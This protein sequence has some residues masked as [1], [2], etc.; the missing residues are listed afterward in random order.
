MSTPTKN[1]DFGISR[2]PFLKAAGAAATGAILSTAGCTSTAF[3]ANAFPPE[4]HTEYG[5]SAALGDGEVSTFVT[6]NENG[7]PRHVG[8]QFSAD[9][10]EGLP[11]DEGAHL[12][13]HLPEDN[14]THY[15]WVG[16]DWNPAGHPPPGVYTVEH[17]D[18]H[19]YTM[20]EADVEAIP[21]GLA[22]YD[23]PDEQRPDGFITEEEAGAP[24]R[25]IA[26]A[27][28]EHLLD[29][30]APEFDGGE[31]SHTFIYG[32]YDP[33]IDPESPDDI[34]EDVPIGP[35]GAEIDVPLYGVGSAGE[36]TFAEPMITKAFLEEQ[37]EE[38]TADIG[39][40][41]VF[42]VAGHY[43]TEY[44]VRYHGND[45][46]YTVTLDAFE[47]FDGAAD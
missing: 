9:A 14:P 3:A 39:M 44:A 23:I 5:D 15:E 26:P 34:I 24:G 13:L 46:A 8:V 22:A 41:D 29:S 27:M 1:S 21:L 43:P 40:P 35:G 19:F 16:V 42:P 6:A 4:K 25:V 38:V 11:E 7:K 17:L 2:R 30:N 10:L 32:V 45:D 37:H 31:F 20:S 18:F 28:G 12:H 33:S 47:P 36:L